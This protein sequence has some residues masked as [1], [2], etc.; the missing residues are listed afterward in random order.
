ME[1][2]ESIKNVIRNLCNKTLVNGCTE[3]EVNSS[4]NKIDQLLRT[5]NLQLDEIFIQQA[6]YKKFKI[7]TG[8]KNAKS[9]NSCILGIAGFC[10][11]RVWRS[12]E[13]LNGKL[14]TVY[15]FFGMETD[16]ALANYLYYIISQAIDTETNKFK[17]SGEYV[18]RTGHGRGFVASFQKGMVGRLYRRLLAMT[19]TRNADESTKTN[20]GSAIIVLKH[21]K[22]ENEFEKMGIK[23]VT[24]SSNNRSISN[25]SSYKSG[26]EAGDRVNLNRPLPNNNKATGYLT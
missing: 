5:Y 16:I 4:M 25:Y 6:E 7:E 26:Q 24:R 2:L 20:V 22:L 18:N 19:Q 23:L 17:N 10:D 12:N 13:Y 15:W 14:Q 11:C 1:N 9:I 3:A 8:S 21:Q